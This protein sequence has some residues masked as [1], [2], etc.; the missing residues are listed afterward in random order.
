MTLLSAQHEF[1]WFNAE[2]PLALLWKKG[3][4]VK[5]ERLPLPWELSPRRRTPIQRKKQLQKH[6]TSPPSKFLVSEGRLK[7]YACYDGK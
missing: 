7:T 3:V 5:K 1:L 6:S 2:L 4:R